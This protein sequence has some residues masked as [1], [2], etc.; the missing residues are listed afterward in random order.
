MASILK[1]LDA[2]MQAQPGRCAG[3]HMLTKAMI[4][5]CL[6]KKGDGDLAYAALNGQKIT[7]NCLSRHG[8]TWAQQTARQHMEW[9]HR[10][11]VHGAER[12][13]QLREDWQRLLGELTAVDAKVDE[14][15]K[16]ATPIT[17]SSAAL[18]ELD[19]ETFARLFHSS[20]FCEAA[21]IALRR[22]DIGKAPSPPACAQG[23]SGVAAGG[24]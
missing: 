21:H 16:K 20:S 19:L 7:E 13:E 4:A 18:D 23:P 14:Q 5:I 6:G 3:K 12:R 1:R 15:Q 8:R 17:M 22:C 10:A 9:G 11:V 2:S 24:S